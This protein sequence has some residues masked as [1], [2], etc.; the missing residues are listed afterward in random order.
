[1]KETILINGVSSPRFPAF[2]SDASINSSIKK[3]INMILIISNIV[4]NNK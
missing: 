2:G 1:M 4:G 3:A